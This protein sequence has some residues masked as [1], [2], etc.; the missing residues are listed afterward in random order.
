MGGDV[1]AAAEAG[2]ARP[3][4]SPDPGRLGNCHPE[5]MLFHFCCLLERLPAHTASVSPHYAKHCHLRKSSSAPEFLS[6]I[7]AVK[8]S[9]G[10]QET[11]HSWVGRA[12]RPPPPST[13]RTHN[14]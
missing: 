2:G 3:A 9:Q 1:E 11:S 6:Y 8:T 12:A 13:A 4:D 5:K 10:R 14:L 7:A